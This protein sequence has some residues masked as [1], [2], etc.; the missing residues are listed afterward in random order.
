[1]ATLSVVVSTIVPHHH[2]H[3]DESVICVGSDL[4]HDHGAENCCCE[5]GGHQSADGSCCAVKSNLLTHF[6]DSRKENRHCD[7]DSD[8]DF[9]GGHIS[10]ALLSR[11]ET[12]VPANVTPARKHEYPPYSN[13]YHS[14]L[15]DGHIG[16]RAPPAA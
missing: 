9:H 8:H 13:L 15:A 3:G 14:V 1:M 5:H 6:G 4:T 7:C 12:A 2:H 11:Y 16:L 10:I